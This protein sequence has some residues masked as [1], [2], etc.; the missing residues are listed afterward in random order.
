MSTSLLARLSSAAWTPQATH[1]PLYCGALQVGYLRRDREPL[2]RAFPQAVQFAADAAHLVGADALSRSA[3]L[4]PLLSAAHAQGFVRGWRNELMD[5]RTAQSDAVLF[6]IER[7]GRMALGVTTRGV[8]LNA[9]TQREGALH[10][11]VQQRALT[12]SVNPGKWDNVADG[13]VSSGETFQQAL[14]KEAWEEAG[15]DAGLIAQAVAVHAFHLAHP[16]GNDLFFE[17]AAVFDLT[18]PADFTPRN[19]DGEVAGFACM[20]MPQLASALREGAFT[21][22]AGIVVADCLIRNHVLDEPA[23]AGFL[24]RLRMPPS[25]AG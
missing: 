1:V 24:E 14:A 8:H 25:N 18:V 20:S 15:I 7:A 23:L 13:G 10:M 3:A 16:D 17:H 4:A 5:V 21:V 12:K 19:L 22:D 2:F 11:W 6:R 9:L